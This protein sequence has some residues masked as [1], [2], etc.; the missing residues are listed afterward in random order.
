[1]RHWDFRNG[2]KRPRHVGALVDNVHVLPRSEDPED[3][4]RWCP[5]NIMFML[6]YNPH[7][8]PLVI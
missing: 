4:V 5:P 2:E 3:L 6:V 1:M 7:E 8:Y